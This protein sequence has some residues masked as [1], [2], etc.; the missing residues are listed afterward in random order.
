MQSIPR[1]VFGLS[2]VVFGA[3]SCFVRESETWQR[4][5][6]LGPVL[7]P[8]AGWAITLALVLGGFAF[9]VPITTRL[10]SIVLAA[11]FGYFTIACISDIVSAPTNPGSYVDIFE[12]LSVCC[13]AFAIAAATVHDRSRFSLFE[14]IARIT[15]A[16]CAVAFAW[17]QVAFLHFT[18]SL[19]PSWIPLGGIFW[20]NLTTLAFALAGIAMLIDRLAR[21]AMQLMA[22]MLALFGL[23]VWVPI[24]VADPAKLTNWTEIALT[25]LIAGASYFVATLRAAPKRASP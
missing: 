17:A 9:L 19:V 8:I 11:V 15:L 2:A 24:I 5:Q 1:F 7:T 18:A 16:I 23:L 4:A 10:A 14:R 3:V 20:T 22:L 13:G 21:E 25:F 12:Q 6:L